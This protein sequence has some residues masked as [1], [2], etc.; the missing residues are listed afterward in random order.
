MEA[1]GTATP[2]RQGGDDGSASR[3]AAF[4]HP[5]GKVDWSGKDFHTAASEEELAGDVDTLDRAIAIIGADDSRVAP[6]G[7]QCALARASLGTVRDREN[8]T[9]SCGRAA[10]AAAAT[11]ADVEVAAMRDRRTNLLSGSQCGM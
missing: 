10:T 1:P 11:T 7:H 9:S 8:K 4:G 5:R 6:T 2:R 3:V